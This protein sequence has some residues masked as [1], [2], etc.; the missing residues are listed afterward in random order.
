MFQV[1][2]NNI[3][4]KYENN[5][6]SKEASDLIAKYKKIGLSKDLALRVYSTQLLG[7]E[8]KLVL[9]GGGNTL[10]TETKNIFGKKN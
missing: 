6:S 9:H 8:K 2:L 10:K 1:I 5:W 3:I 7:R 4:K